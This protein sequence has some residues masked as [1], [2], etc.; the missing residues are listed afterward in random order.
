[1]NFSLFQKWAIATLVA[2]LFLIFVGGFVRASGAGLGC[3]DWPRCW[4]SWLP[5]ADVSAIDPDLYDISQFNHT[6][7][8]IE[9]VNSIVGVVVGLLVVGTFVLSLR[10][11]KTRPAVTLGAFLAVLL[12][13]FQGWLGGVVV[14]SGLAHGMITLHMI[15]AVILFC[16]L[17]WI[18]Y[19]AAAGGAQF[20]F[21]GR[22]R[23]LLRGITLA[24]FLCTAVQIVLGAEVR[25]YVEIASRSEALERSQ[26]IDLA[27]WRYL[28]HRTF[29]WTLVVASV[30]LIVF[31]ARGRASG[32]TFRLIVAL[33]LGVLVQVGSGAAMAWFA[34]P[35]S[36]QIIHLGVST[37]LACLSFFLIVGLAKRPILI[38][39]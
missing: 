27:G 3:P 38:A 6:K 33:A 2:T 26:W 18:A 35:P 16:L 13:V 8:W 14:K 5:P 22:H 31:A 12:V 28:F 1:M 21:P 20:A 25:E 7:M 17:I 39:A 36:A 9:Y 11:R 30:A 4:G 37:V 24:F 34:L 19:R 29:A 23:R 15:V 32:I 10:Y